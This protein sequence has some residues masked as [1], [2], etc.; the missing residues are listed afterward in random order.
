MKSFHLFSRSRSILL[1]SR[2][3]NTF[4]IN[5]LRIFWPR[6]SFLAGNWTSVFRGNAASLAHAV[7]CQ[8]WMLL[9]GLFSEETSKQRE[10]CW[11]Y[12]TLLQKI[13]QLILFVC[14]YIIWRHSNPSELYNFKWNAR[15]YEQIW[16]LGASCH[17]YATSVRVNVKHINHY[18]GRLSCPCL[19][20][21]VQIKI[22]LN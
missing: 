7:V 15:K 19:S 10:R 22:Y 18:S 21:R 2:P 13:L 14:F 3:W 16:R 6:K 20:K 8:V 5:T 1:F 17:R 9:A 4:Q 12:V 11:R